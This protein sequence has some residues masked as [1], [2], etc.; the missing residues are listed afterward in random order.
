[1]K[2]DYCPADNLNPASLRGF[3]LV[4]PPKKE[5]A[6][7]TRKIYRNIEYIFRE[8]LPFKEEGA[9]SCASAKIYFI[10]L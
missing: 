9:T 8:L 4:N 2:K 10:V 5:G 6:K 3:V 7:Y 1:M